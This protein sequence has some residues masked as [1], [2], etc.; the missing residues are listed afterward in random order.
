MQTR[1]RWFGALRTV[2]L[3]VSLS[4]V[5][6]AQRDGFGGGPFTAGPNIPYD[7]RFTFARI[8]YQTAPG[9]FWA[10]G[11][12]YCAGGYWGGG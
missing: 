5:A 2:A 9:G 10:G 3:V 8:R 1:S 6:L 4:G 7:G 12:G 11:G